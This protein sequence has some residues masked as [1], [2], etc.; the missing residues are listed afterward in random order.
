MARMTKEERDTKRYISNKLASQGYPTY[1]DIFSEFDLHLTS[2][3]RVLGYMVPAK[4]YITINRDI[5]EDNFS[6]IIRHEILHFYLEHEQRMLKHLA[7]KHG[8]DYSKLEDMSIEDLKKE[9][10][11]DKTFNF[12]GDYEISNRAYTEEDKETIRKLHALV[13]E[14]DHPGWEDLS[15]EEMYD[16]LMELKQKDKE[17][18]L[19][20]IEEKQK[21]E[22]E[23][24][25]TP[26]DNDE[27]EGAEGDE[28]DNGGDGYPMP[29]DDSNGSG[30]GDEEE[31]DKDNGEMT[32]GSPISSDGSREEDEDEEDDGGDGTP[33]SSDENKEEKDGGDS[34]TSNNEEEEER[35]GDPQSKNNGSGENEDS[36]NDSPKFVY[37]SFIDENT[38]LDSNGNPVS[39]RR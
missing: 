37:G 4:G 24:P 21:E 39:I 2:N 1:A 5:D 33:I 15:V 17:N 36:E 3:P 14:D 35:P 16:K 12:A 8:I 23:N 13:T 32:D 11:K 34:D 26:E 38:F 31:E 28:E 18:A 30:E 7:K 29:S 10:Y 20:D 19:D 27:G 9:L 6:V 25:I 22:E